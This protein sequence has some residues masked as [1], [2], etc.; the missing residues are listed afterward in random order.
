MT[1]LENAMLAGFGS[2]FGWTSEGGG[3]L[4]E[5]LMGLETKGALI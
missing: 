4:V 1:L 5:I 2:K 3:V